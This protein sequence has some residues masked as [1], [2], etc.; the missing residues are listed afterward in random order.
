L[1]TN[2]ASIGVEEL[3]SKTGSL[4]FLKKELLKDS[5]GPGETRGG[6]GQEIKL[7]NRADTTIDINFLGR[8]GDFPAKGL[9]GGHDGTPQKVYVG[10]ERVPVKSDQQLEPNK[11]VTY[12]EAGG[13][14]FGDPAD[15]E[16]ERIKYDLQNG[17]ISEQRA[18]ET[19]GYDP[20]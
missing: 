17:Y 1:P 18:R 9:Y 12:E 3:E 10:D 14:G 6:L 20:N 5:G 19:Y 8:K 4:L 16:P 13:G 11:V 2:L 7:Q 15:R